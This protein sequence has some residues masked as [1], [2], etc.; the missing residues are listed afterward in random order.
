MEEF[1]D[2]GS[3][4]WVSF[5]PEHR[6]IIDHSIGERNRIMANDIVRKTFNRI[7]GNPLFVTDGL[8]FYKDALLSRYG[9]CNRA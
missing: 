1:E 4:I 3:W 5:A 6:L 2:D 7:A 9:Q 8:K